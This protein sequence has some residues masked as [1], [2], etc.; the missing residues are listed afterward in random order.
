M[1]LN[2]YH[3]T[4]Y[5]FYRYTLGLDSKMY[6]SYPHAYA[7]QFISLPII[8]NFWTVYLFLFGI[9]N[10]FVLVS[11]LVSTLIIY[12]VNLTYYDK[13][14]TK[15]IVELVMHE[16]SNNEENL[17]KI[18]R[19]AIRYLCISIIAFICGVICRHSLKAI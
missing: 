17:K 16:T 3:Y 5:I 4:Y 2:F 9:N 18:R 12:V 14:R 19:N 13:Y 6:G 11:T 8:L 7:S 15:K 10:Q 1:T